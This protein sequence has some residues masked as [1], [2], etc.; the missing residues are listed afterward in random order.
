MA[1][2]QLRGGI[3]FATRMAGATKKHQAP[4]RGD[5]GAGE[6][7]AFGPFRLRRGERLLEES[8][9]PIPI[10]GRAFDLLLT[11]TDRAGEVISSRELIDLVWPDVVVEEANLRVCVAALR[12][13]LGDNRNQSRYILNV[14]GRGYTF[15]APL[16]RVPSESEAMFAVS[17]AVIRPK[18]RR[19]ALQ[20]LVSRNDPADILPRLSSSRGFAD[21]VEGDDATLHNPVVARLADILR[22]QSG[23]AASCFA[24][25]GAQPE[26]AG[27]IRQPAPGPAGL[28]NDDLEREVRDFL[29]DKRILVVLDDCSHVIGTATS[30]FDRLFHAAISVHFLTTSRDALRIAAENPQACLPQGD[31]PVETPSLIEALRKIG[32][33][34]FTYGRWHHEFGGLTGDGIRRLEDL[35][36]ENQRL[37]RAIADLTLEKVLLK[38]GAVE[39]I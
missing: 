32:I 21:L 20:L 14:P 13:A 12:K 26:R 16:R 36:K 9:V 17:R 28:G 19:A 7:L 15:V 30:L 35:E 5:M 31:P 18:P 33:T 39:R 23:Y 22:E 2:E 37:R 3:A 1:S 10:G 6:C 11:L 8:G 38:E 4:R 25:V 34:A 29:A 24:I 27:E